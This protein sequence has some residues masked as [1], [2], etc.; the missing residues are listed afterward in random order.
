MQS[1][2]SYLRWTLAGLLLFQA[3]LLAYCARVHSPTWDEPG[4]LIAGLSHWKLGRFDLYAVNPPLVRLIA[5]APVH[6]GMSPE[7]DFTSYSTNSAHRSEVQVARDFFGQRG[8]RAFEMLWVARLAV[9]PFAILGTVLCF[10]ISRRIFQSPQAGLIAALL[11]VGSPWMWAYGPLITPDMATAVMGLLSVYSFWLYWENAT[12][13]R[14]LFCSVATGLAM[15]T[16]SFWLVLP[17]VYGLVVVGGWLYGWIV[18]RVAME[19][20]SAAQPPFSFGKRIAGVL[21]IGC[22]GLLLLNAGYGFRG[23]FQRLD[24][25]K[26]VSRS[27]ASSSSLPL[28]GPRPLNGYVRL[29]DLATPVQLVGINPPCP[30]CNSTDESTSSSENAAQV[31]E[32]Q[33]PVREPEFW[34]A[35]PGNRFAGSWMGALRLPLPAQFIQGIDVQRRDFE[36][37]LYRPE[38]ASYFNG[39]WRQGGWWYFY[40]VGLFLKTPLS[41]WILIAMAVSA[42]CL[43]RRLGGIDVRYAGLLGLWI[44]A[45]GVLLMLS[46]NVG[47]NRYLRYALPIVPVLVITAS[48]A[49]LWYTSTHRESSAGARKLAVV[50][51]LLVVGLVA[52]HGF[53]GVLYHRD[54]LS[55]FNVAAGGPNQG[56]LWFTDS[57]VDWG[58]DL[59]R[60]ADWLE[61]NPEAQSSFGLAYFGCIN[62]SDLGIKYRCPVPSVS[63]LTARA[64]SSQDGISAAWAE[65]YYAISKNYLVGHPMP[66]PVEDGSQRFLSYPAL[67]FF[68]QMEPIDRIGKT[69]LVYRLDANQAKQ[70]HQFLGFPS[71]SSGRVTQIDHVA[72]TNTNSRTSPQLS[73]TP[74][75]QALST[76]SKP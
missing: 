66:L 26:F 68:Q 63:E 4:H 43:R 65:G 1:S 56:H 23:S 33:K 24:S 34:D 54:A 76:T 28:P 32:S 6:F 64:M 16:K 39:Q 29:G 13:G 73:L 50:C 48:G 38:W 40:F 74:S 17:L 25:M 46:V 67:T 37:G 18:Q 53:A 75:D 7:I 60:V 11:W 51:Q 62:P 19:P 8:S 5:T 31:T 47:L 69:M 70:F 61:R 55:Y 22:F 58:Q 44:A 35:R 59:G 49:V 57:N 41:L 27:F 20:E 10:L 9:I 2:S 21:A 72:V 14:F 30:H 45:G 42:V 3:T 52:I 15:L 71:P 12:L 36:M